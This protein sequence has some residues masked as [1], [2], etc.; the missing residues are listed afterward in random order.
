MEMESAARFFTVPPGTLTVNDDAP[1]PGRPRTA[2]LN[3]FRRLRLT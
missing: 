2:R 1:P 3:L